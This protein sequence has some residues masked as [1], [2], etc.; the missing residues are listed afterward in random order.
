ML[1]TFSGLPGTGKSTI[2]RLLAQQLGAVYL[3]VDTIEQA[4]RSGEESKN[5]IGPEGYFVLYGL[6]RENLLLGSTVITDSVNDL[7]L[8][9]NAYRDIALLSGSPLL[10]VEVICSDRNKH[11][12]RVENRV[13][14]IKDLKLPDWQAVEQREYQPWERDRLQLDSAILSAQQCVDAIMQALP[15]SFETQ[16]RV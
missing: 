9:R 3:R 14:D 5:A 8:I 1:I 15:L 6:A 7:Q 11:R 2:A 12:F 10:E 4:L 13:S 16:Q